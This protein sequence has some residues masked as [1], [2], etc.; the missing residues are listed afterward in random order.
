VPWV[1]LVTALLSVL[2]AWGLQHLYGVV[3]QLIKK[4]KTN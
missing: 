2:L 1:F 3:G 4:E